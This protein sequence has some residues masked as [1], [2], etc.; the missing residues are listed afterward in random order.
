MQL[1]FEIDGVLTKIKFDDVEEFAFSLDSE[2][3]LTDYV[4]KI[5]DLNSEIEI[6]PVDYNQIDN[7]ED[8]SDNIK[9]LLEYLYQI[10]QKFNE[11]FKEVHESEEG[12]A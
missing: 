6:S 8:L 7:F 10:P 11:V 1:K 9:K 12:D 2:I 5:S 4:Q 3:D